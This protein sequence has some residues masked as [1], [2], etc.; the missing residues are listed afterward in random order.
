M[1]MCL[2][3]LREYLK[4]KETERELAY[5]KSRVRFSDYLVYMPALDRLFYSPVENPSRPPS[6]SE[7]EYDQLGLEACEKKDV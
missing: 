2:Q 6:K 5:Q 1:S 4:K 7:Q 3:R